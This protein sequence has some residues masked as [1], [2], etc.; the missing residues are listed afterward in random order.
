MC[1]LRD[2]RRV[3]DCLQ[4]ARPGDTRERRR[5][6]TFHVLSR[7][8][9]TL[10]D[11]ERAIEDQAPRDLRV[12][13]VRRQDDDLTFPDPITAIVGPNG[14]GKSNI[15]DAIRWVMGEQ[16]AKHLRGRAMEDVIFAGSESRGPAGLAE[17]SLTFDAQRAGRAAPR[18][19]ACPGARLAPE[20]IVVTRRLYRDGTS[21][22]LINDVRAACATSSSSSSAPASARRPTRSS[23]RAASASSCRRGRRTAAPSSTRPRASPSTR[24]RRRRPSGRWIRRGS[25]CCASRTSSASSTGGCARCGCRRRRPSATSA[26]RP[27]CKDLELWSSAQRYLGHLAEEK[28]LGAELAGVRASTRVGE[29]R[30][31]RREEAAVEAERLAVTEETDRAGG[32]EGRAVRAVEQGAARHAARQ[33][34]EDEATELAARAEAGRREIERAASAGGGARAATSRSSR[35]G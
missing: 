17:V 29:R 22:Y 2:A 11:Q 19:A 34:Y 9:G 33:H 35:A 16:S 5:D 7:H 27:S 32:G 31:W 28:S 26:T 13:V 8:C 30:R 25:T 10:G 24:R 15:V 6:D 1:N 21:E 12:Q 3:R 4:R 23:S 20:E 18:R 14:C